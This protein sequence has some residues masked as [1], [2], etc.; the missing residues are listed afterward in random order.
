MRD[1]NHINSV[2]RTLKILEVF[3]ESSRPLTLTEVGNLTGLAKST[4]QRFL[5]TLL[6]LG[7]LNREK[8]KRYTLSPRIISLA[9]HFLNTSNLG[10]LAKPYLDELSSELSM[11]THLAVLDSCDIIILYRRQVRNFFNFGIYAGSNGWGAEEPE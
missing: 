9:F 3:G 11:S 7:Y 4:A 5:D 1:S 8:D 10:S 6:F 2:A